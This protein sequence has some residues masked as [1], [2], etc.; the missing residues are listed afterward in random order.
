MSKVEEGGG[1]VDPH[2]PFKASCEYFF[3]EASRV[4]RN[5]RCHCDLL[6]LKLLIYASPVFAIRSASTGG[7]FFI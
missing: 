2:P 3:F 7:L 6:F 1:G 4:N 5:V